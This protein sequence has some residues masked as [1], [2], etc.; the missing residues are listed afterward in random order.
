MFELTDDEL[1]D[2]AQ[3]ARSALGEKFERGAATNC[4]SAPWN[5][6]IRAERERLR[7]AGRGRQQNYWASHQS[8]AAPTLLRVIRPRATWRS[9]VR[10]VGIRLRE[11]RDHSNRGQGVG[12]GPSLK[13]VHYPYTYHK[14]AHKSCTEKAPPARRRQPRRAAMGESVHGFF[15]VSK[16]CYSSCVCNLRSH[17]NV[18]NDRANWRGQH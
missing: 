14:N 10:A 17:R 1:R 6:G 16:F 5:E 7:A 3:A 15:L 12:G 9:H 18:G 2:A 13:L 8:F 4:E 11:N